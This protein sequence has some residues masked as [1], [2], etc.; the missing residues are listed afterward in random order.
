MRPSASPTFVR[1]FA[2]KKR[3]YL[4]KVVSTGT[5]ESLRSENRTID[6]SSWRLK[7]SPE[8]PRIRIVGRAI[9]RSGAT[10]GNSRTRHEDCQPTST[11]CQPVFQAHACADVATIPTRGG[12]WRKNLRVRLLEQRRVPPQKITYSTF[13]RIVEN[14]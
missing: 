5:S 14:P 7:V 2:V 12:R 1:R 9:E 4:D 11:D 10:T 6:V 8:P 13:E 3:R